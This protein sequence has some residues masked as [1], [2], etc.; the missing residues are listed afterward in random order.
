MYQALPDFLKKHKYQDIVD[1]A[2]TVHQTAWNVEGPVFMWLAQHP[3][4]VQWFNDFMA[5]GRKGLATW[6]DVY[7]VEEQTKDWGIQTR[8]SSSMLVEISAISAQS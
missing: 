4:R 8:P 6:L 2:N 3:E 7:P 5:H 1:N